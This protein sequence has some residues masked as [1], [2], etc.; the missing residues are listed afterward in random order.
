MHRPSTIPKYALHKASGHARV[1]IAGREYFL[2]RYGTDESWERYQR[3]VAEQV[4]AKGGRPADRHRPGDNAGLTVVELIGAYWTWAK[5]YYA[6]DGRPSKHLT[7]VKSALKLLRA[8]Y[9]HSRVADFGPLALQALQSRMVDQGLARS[10]INGQTRRLK[11][12][13]RWGVSQEL[14]PPAIYQA[15]A[16]VAG[17]RRGRTAARETEP[18][19][20]VAITVVEQTLAY[21]PRVVADMVRLQLLLGCRPNEIC[22]LRPV[23]VVLDGRIWR[24]L[25]GDHKTAHLGHT[26][27]IYVGPRAQAILAPYLNRTPES[28]CFS[29]AESERAR[30]AE[31]RL[32]R[33]TRVQPV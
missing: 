7:V 29:P 11:H 6:L 20:P 24:Y 26:R 25:P 2:G 10:Y 5:S 17:L 13:F 23:D 15:L 22:G 27:E 18:V 33:R 19:G 3:L 14:V 16:T 8:H 21:L 9:G 1:I 30:H 4:L 31:M 32:R 12:T 28:Y